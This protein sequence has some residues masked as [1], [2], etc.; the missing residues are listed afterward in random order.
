MLTQTLEPKADATE[1]RTRLGYDFA[2]LGLRGREARVARIRQAARQTAERIR[3]ADLA[4]R[5]SEQAMLAEL[6]T[7]TYRLLDPRKRRQTTERVQLCILSESDLELQQASRDCLLA[8]PLP[9][10]KLDNDRELKLAKVELLSKLRDVE[11][12][13]RRKSSRVGSVVVGACVALA[14]LVIALLALL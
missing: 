3:S 4:V 9:S 2:L 1:H 12:T 6:A 11:A 13:P 7:S 14:S 5:E 8:H 10:S